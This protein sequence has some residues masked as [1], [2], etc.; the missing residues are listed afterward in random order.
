MPPRCPPTGELLLA[1]RRGWQQEGHSW[2][3]QDAGREVLSDRVQC[4]G[5][6]HKDSGMDVIA[7]LGMRR[8]GCSLRSKTCECEQG[9]L[10]AGSCGRG[11]GWQA[12]QPAACGGKQKPFAAL[13][14]YLDGNRDGKNNI[15]EWLSPCN[16]CGHQRPRLSVGTRAAGP[17]RWV[18]CPLVP[19]P[20]LVG[21]GSRRNAGDGHGGC[22]A[23]GEPS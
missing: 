14:Y 22:G 6:G 5:K 13:I 2:A 1:A 11:Q 20:Q 4:S 8:D 23:P 21:R 17:G 16:P 7:S 10:R 3:V 9:W 15:P 19:C 18:P 12:Q